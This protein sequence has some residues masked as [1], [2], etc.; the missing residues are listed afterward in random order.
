MNRYFSL[1]TVVLLLSAGTSG[2][3][4]L[5]IHTPDYTV[6]TATGD[7]M[8]PTHDECGLSIVDEDYPIS[9]LDEKQ[10]I[11][12]VESSNGNTTGDLILHRFIVVDEAENLY[13]YEDGYENPNQLY[14][15]TKGDN[16]RV[17][18]LNKV[19][20]YRGVEVQHID[21]PNFAC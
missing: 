4:F 16:M 19:N 1:F 17:G 7:S 12:L 21:I 3:L 20:S 2:V 8:I 11:V 10:D 5:D 9:E 13:W 6:Y 18:E 14:I 15:K